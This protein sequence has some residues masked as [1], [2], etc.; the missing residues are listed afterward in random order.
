MYTYVYLY[1]HIWI[2][3]I[4]QYNDNNGCANVTNFCITKSISFYLNS[5]RL[6]ELFWKEISINTSWTTVN[7]NLY[8]FQRVERKYWN[9]NASK[10][11]QNRAKNLTDKKKNRYELPTVGSATFKSTTVFTSFFFFQNLVWGSNVILEL[12]MFIV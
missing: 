4:F 5:K 11:S 9:I 2:H 7:W 8:F 6:F 3:F 12:N 1:T 10:K